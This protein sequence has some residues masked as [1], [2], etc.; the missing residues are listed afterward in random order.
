MDLQTFSWLWAYG[1]VV[2][3]TAFLNFADIH[4]LQSERTAPLHKSV[5]FWLYLFGQSVISVTAAFLLYEKAGVPASEWWLVAVAS[6]FAGFSILQSFTIK[7]GDKG[8]D[9]RDLFDAWKRRVIT[10][11]A[12]VNVSRKLARQLKVARSLAKHFSTD[13]LAGFVRLMARSV[14]EDPEAVVQSLLRAVNP[15]LSLGQWMASMDVDSAES[16]LVEKP[17]V[18]EGSE[19]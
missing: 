18:T 10:E 7:F 19:A 14:E 2:L 13:D 11:I 6:A 5:S 3:L 17:N 12:A 8:I 4:F 1:P 15:G 16:L 9:A